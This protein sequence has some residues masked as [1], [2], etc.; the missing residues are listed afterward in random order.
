MVEGSG[1]FAG[2][3][4]DVEVFGVGAFV[5]AVGSGV[6]GWVTEAGLVGAREET[7]SMVPEALI[8]FNKLSLGVL[9]VL[10]VKGCAWGVGL[11]L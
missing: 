5:G 6:V 1:V 11:G 3:S 7:V 8:T 2:F 4:I 9:G 10:S